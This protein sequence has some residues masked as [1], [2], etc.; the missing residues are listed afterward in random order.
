MREVKPYFMRDCKIHNVFADIDVSLN[1][2]VDVYI[3]FQCLW[4][5][6]DLCYSFHFCFKGQDLETIHVN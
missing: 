4:D 6:L 1:G 2:A 5:V 3:L